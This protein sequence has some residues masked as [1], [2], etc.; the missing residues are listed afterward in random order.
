MIT[1]TN[2]CLPWE[3][4]L[5]IML[6]NDTWH[7]SV[8]WRIQCTWFWSFYNHKD[9]TQSYEIAQNA[10]CLQKIIWSLLNI[11][12]FDNRI[13]IYEIIKYFEVAATCWQ[14]ITIRQNC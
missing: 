13:V 3:R 11:H 7:K 4:D 9:N 14:L 5:V 6:Y 12:V 8:Y 1:E 2:T 10:V